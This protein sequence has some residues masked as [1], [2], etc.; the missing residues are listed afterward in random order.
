MCPLP[1]I[2]MLAYVDAATSIAT[3]AEFRCLTTVV[4]SL[5]SAHRDRPYGT[6]EEGG[7]GDRRYTMGTGRGAGPG[8]FNFE[9]HPISY[10][11]SLGNWETQSPPNGKCL[12]IGVTRNMT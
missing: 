12:R 11:I 5:R 1:P 4:L 9:C 7:M 6:E 3:G 2:I 10:L 8:P